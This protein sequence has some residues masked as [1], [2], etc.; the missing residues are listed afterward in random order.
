MGEEESFITWT[1]LPALTFGCYIIR[2][3][4]YKQGQL[5]EFFALGINVDA[6][7]AAAELFQL[8]Y[9]QNFANHLVVVVAVVVSVLLLLLLLD[10][11]VFFAFWFIL[12]PSILFWCILFFVLFCYFV[13]VTATTNT[14]M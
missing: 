3:S 4:R 5:K 10:F 2:A 8:T 13:S 6:A 7:A 12:A 11:T 1:E 14:F 9:A